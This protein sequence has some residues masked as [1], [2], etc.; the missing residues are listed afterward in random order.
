MRNI[1]VTNF[2]YSGED[3][4]IFTNKETAASIQNKLDAQRVWYNDIFE[5]PD[6]ERQYY[7]F[8]PCYL[9]D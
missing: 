5:V 2:D 7:L 6:S 8:E 1:L 3:V 9:N 4:M